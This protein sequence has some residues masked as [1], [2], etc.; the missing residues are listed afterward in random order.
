MKILVNSETS[1]EA[2]SS[3][4]RIGVLLSTRI[5]KEDRL[6][7]CSVDFHHAVRYISGNSRLWCGPLMSAILSTMKIYF[8]ND[9]FAKLPHD[10][11]EDVLRWLTAADV[12]V[13][14]QV[15]S[16]FH[17]WCSADTLWTYFYK[18]RFSG[19]AMR[20]SPLSVSV[21]RMYQIRFADPIIGDK[22]QAAWNGKFRLN[23]MEMLR[24]Q[25]YWPAEIIDKDPQQGYKIRYTG[26]DAERWDQWVLRETIRW[27]VD[28]NSVEK[29]RVGDVV[30]IW[31]HGKTVPGA[32][33]CAI[34]SEFDVDLNLYRFDD[35]QMS[36]DPLF[37]RRD[38]IRK[39]HRPFHLTDLPATD[40]S[41]PLSIQGYNHPGSC[42]IC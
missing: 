33:L 15:N 23:A 2:I 25:A 31:C 18:V 42:L 39:V 24:G 3:L 4:R 16:D 32:W 5:S 22:I 17:R 1:Y 19:N 26:W 37:V 6:T 9:K 34:V 13:L 30:E 41:V 7:Y 20:Q 14:C 11:I 38:F 35:L 40:I 8:S 36:G 29:I 27:P 21:K 28:F 12:C 10:L